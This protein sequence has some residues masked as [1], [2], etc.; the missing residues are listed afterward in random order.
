MFLMKVG[1]LPAVVERTKPSPSWAPPIIASAFTP[2]ACAF[3]M[4]AS[5]T[6]GAW[7]L[8]APFT[9]CVGLPPSDPLPGA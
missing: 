9:S 3:A 6:V 2:E 8:P 1:R 4:S 7:P 5:S